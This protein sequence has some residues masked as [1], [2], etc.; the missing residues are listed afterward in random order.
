[1]SLAL[2]LGYS[3]FVAKPLSEWRSN[4]SRYQ[5]LFTIDAIYYLVAFRLAGVVLI[6]M[7]IYGLIYNP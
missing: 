6:L 3:F 4:M 5:Y 7:G 1:M 2:F